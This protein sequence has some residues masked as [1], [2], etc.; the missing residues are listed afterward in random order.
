MHKKQNYIYVGIDLHKETHTAVI[1]NCWNEKLG[2]IT[3]AN[4]PSDFKKL[5][6][7]VQK[8]SEGLIPVYG[9]ENEGSYGR[10][11]A[12]Y[13][14]ED[15]QMVKDVNPSLSY[16]QRLSA[17]TTKKDDGYDALCVANVLLN[18]L[19]KLPDASPHDAY[20]TL[21]Q[22][23]NRRESLVQSLIGLKNQLH[24]QLAH[25]YSSYKEFFSVID[26]NTSLNFWE[27][28]PSQKHLEGVEV[29]DLAEILRSTSHNNCSTKKA[30]KI[31]DAINEDGNINKDYQEIRDFIVRSIVRDIRNKKQEMGLAEVELIKLMSTLGY[32]LETMP[33]IDT[34]TASKIVAE[35][36]DISR[37][38]NA[39]K[40]ARFA[41]VAPVLFSSAG[42]G[43]E[44]KSRQG[45][46][47]LHGVFYFLAVQMVQT[48]PKSGKPRNPIFYDYFKR[49]ISEG[50][51]KPQALV[52]VMRRLVN[53]IYGMMKNKTEYREPEVPF[54]DV[55]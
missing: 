25:S 38:Q 19:D 39:D 16:A 44:Q 29:E 30:Q 22:L 41:G 31:L 5:I 24:E 23:V 47:R 17:P 50:K 46:R 8:H 37:F 20:W 49:K 43:K 54:M 42:K 7:E 36:G 14:L 48:A 12:I 18:L 9:L 51:T 52:C 55:V 33:G 4:K 45:N 32:R 10:N 2:Q 34:I 3:F 26:T 28:Y 15:K 11:L 53:I 35:I 40:L 1:I 6:T 27:L 13:L 21:A